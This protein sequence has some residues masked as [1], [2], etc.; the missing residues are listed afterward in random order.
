MVLDI[1]SLEECGVLKGM[2]L[3]NFCFETF[4]QQFPSR[5]GMAVLKGLI[6]FQFYFGSVVVLEGLVLHNFYF[7]RVWLS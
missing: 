4:F 7:G 2:I 5:D 6:F 1:V 3:D